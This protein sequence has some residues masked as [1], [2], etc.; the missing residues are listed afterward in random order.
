M[1]SVEVVVVEEKEKRYIVTQEE[2][3]QIQKTITKLNKKYLKAN[4]KI[5]FQNEKDISKVSKKDLI[6]Y[7]IYLN[8][9]YPSIFIN[10]KSF[11]QFLNNTRQRKKRDIVDIINYYITTKN[12]KVT[13]KAEI[14]GTSSPELVN[15]YIK[16]KVSKVVK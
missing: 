6:N 13:Y 5:H 9:Q 2:N 1:T 11:K 14:K 8:T 7:I 3:E 15:V 4:G 10:H 16:K 12:T